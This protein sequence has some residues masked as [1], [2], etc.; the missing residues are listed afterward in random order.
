MEQCR[1]Y[2]TQEFRKK[3]KDRLGWEFGKSRKKGQLYST[4][5]AD[6][7]KPER[8]IVL[9]IIGIISIFVTYI[10]VSDFDLVKVK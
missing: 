5:Q 8:Q 7:A 6:P 3:L 2:E 1:G 4:S 10:T 9:S